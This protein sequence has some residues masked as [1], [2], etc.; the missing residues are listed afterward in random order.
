MSYKQLSDE[1]VIELSIDFI[2][3]GQPI[4]AEI[5]ARLDSLGLKDILSPTCEEF[6]ED[7]LP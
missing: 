4:P 7:I 2:K 5:S 3:Q 6:D 1:G